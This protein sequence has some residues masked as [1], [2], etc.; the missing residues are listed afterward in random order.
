MPATR[1][2]GT[3]SH[4]CDIGLM[5]QTPDGRYWLRFRDHKGKERIQQA[6]L[7]DEEVALVIG[8][9]MLW[10]RFLRW[11]VRRER[12]CYNPSSRRSP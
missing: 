2:P 12:H 11:R 10:L 4:G 6:A 1:E 7:P 3:H 5:E 8:D 9:R